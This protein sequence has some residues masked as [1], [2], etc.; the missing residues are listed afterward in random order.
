MRELTDA[1][2][3]RR[4]MQTLGAEADR[5]GRVYFTGGAT[6]VLLGWRPTTIDADISIVPESDRLLRAL[7]GLK[8]TLRMNVELASPA[9]FI[10]ELPGWEQR[11]PFIAREGKLSFHHYDLYAQ[12]L[13][14]I[15]RGHARDRQDVQ[16]MLG[17]GLVDPQ[18]LRELF[19]QIEPELYRYP[20][21]DPPS[22]RRAVEE[23]L[24]APP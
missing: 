19:A 4:F 13:A 7:P 14:K 3:L 10:P 11:S 6:A 2:R 23:A 1:P 24:G 17:R 21:L 8:E 5:E 22:F 18:R 16:E 9:H 15:E 12:A 20:A